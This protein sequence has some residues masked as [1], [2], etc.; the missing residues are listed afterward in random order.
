MNFQEYVFTWTK[1]MYMRYICAHTDIFILIGIE[2]AYVLCTVAYKSSIDIRVLDKFSIFRQEYSYGDPV[3]IGSSK[4]I[5]LSIV[6]QNIVQQKTLQ[7]SSI[8]YNSS[9]LK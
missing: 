2:N 5:S 1:N 3:A 6:V 4:S 7:L 9:F 8:D